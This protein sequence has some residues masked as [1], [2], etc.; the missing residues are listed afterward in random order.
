MNAYRAQ[1]RKNSDVFT[2]IVIV[3]AMVVAFATAYYFGHG[4]VQDLKSFLE[5][6]TAPSSTT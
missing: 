5:S 1:A 4:A 3:V 6:L 2:L